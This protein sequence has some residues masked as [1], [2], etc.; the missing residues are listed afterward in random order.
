MWA[1]IGIAGASLAS[2]LLGADASRSAAN[3]Q[4]AATDRATQSQV[5][6]GAQARSDLTPFREGGVSALQ[7][8]MTLTGIGSG[9]DKNDPRYKSIY[10][11]LSANADAA[12]QKQFGMSIFDKNSGLSAPGERARFEDNL[13]QQASQQYTSQYGNE[14]KNDP[15]YGALTKPFNYSLA[16]FY[17]DPSYNFQLQQGEQGIERAMSA[18]GL[19]S[20]TPGLKALMQWNQDYAGTAYNSAFT[21]AFGVDQ[22]NKQTSYNF[23]QGIAGM[24]QNSAAQTGS[25][26]ANMASGAASSLIAGGQA[27]A[28]GTLGAASSVNN[29]VQGGLGNYMYNQR[30]Q[31][32]MGLYGNLMNMQQPTSNFDYTGTTAAGGR[33]YGG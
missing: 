26:G 8:L 23:L 27:Q 14:T 32:T 31:Q 19:S 1:G 2:G 5:A 33:Q 11:S 22:S 9:V 30:F 20:S 6:A 4:A 16:D 29:A 21:R 25:V 7:R 24:G 17:K 18:R 3:T 10:D 13:H 28:A 15:Q 12:H